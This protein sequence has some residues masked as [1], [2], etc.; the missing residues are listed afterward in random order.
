MTCNSFTINVISITAS[1]PTFE[2]LFRKYN[3]S[4]NSS[5]SVDG[6]SPPTEMVSVNIP[7]GAFRTVAALSNRSS[8]HLS[9]VRIETSVRF[10]YP[11]EFTT[12]FD[13]SVILS[14]SFE[15]VALQS[16][17][18][19]DEVLITFEKAEVCCICIRVTCCLKCI[20]CAVLCCVKL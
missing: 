10:L 15:G 1:V 5:I 12:N 6:S 8:I 11:D 14:V 3:H 16:F 2:G 17:S 18:T 7:A 13:T 19:S 9:I 4:S 20:K